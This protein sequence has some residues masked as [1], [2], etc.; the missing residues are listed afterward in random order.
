[1]NEYYANSTKADNNSSTENTFKTNYF[2]P[3]HSNI[4]KR[5]LVEFLRNCKKS[6]IKI[7]P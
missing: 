3:L 7:K 2:R 6:K 4:R 5:C 1:M